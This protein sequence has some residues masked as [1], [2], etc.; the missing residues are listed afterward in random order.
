MRHRGPESGPDGIEVEW[1]RGRRAQQRLTAMRLEADTAPTARL[2]WRRAFR[3]IITWYLGGWGTQGKQLQPPCN[4]R[5][6]AEMVRKEVFETIGMR[7]FQRGAWEPSPKNE[8]R[9]GLHVGSV[10]S[11]GPIG[12]W[13]GGNSRRTQ[14]QLS[15]GIS[16]RRNDGPAQTQPFFSTHNH[17]SGLLCVKFGLAS[18]AS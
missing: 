16:T 15:E 4:R 12:R 5:F 13:E 2:D 17:P 10:H 8:S 9:T 7:G 18:R 3:N 6:G 14:S 1:I 11:N